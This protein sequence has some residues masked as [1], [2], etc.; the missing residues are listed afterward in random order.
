MELTTLT[1]KLMFITIKVL[2]TLLTIYNKRI[3]IIMNY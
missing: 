3:K 2:S 1:R